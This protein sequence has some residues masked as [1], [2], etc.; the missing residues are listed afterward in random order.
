MNK[1][2]TSRK[3]LPRSTFGEV[4]LAVA[5]IAASV[6]LTYHAV[7]EAR[8]GQ[9]I[10]AVLDTLGFASILFGFC[11][12]PVNFTALLLPWVFENVAVSTPFRKV[13]WIFICLGYLML[14]VA[15]GNR[16]GFI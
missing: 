2:E 5:L 15:W 1:D 9:S 14:I 12:D 7:T 10:F 6:G 3:L 13:G 16:H 11:F 8:Q 4:L